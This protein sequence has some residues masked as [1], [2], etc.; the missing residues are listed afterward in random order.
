MNTFTLF[1]WFPWH[2]K[3]WEC[4]LALYPKVLVNFTCSAAVQARVMRLS[5]FAPSIFY[6]EMQIRREQKLGKGRDAVHMHIACILFYFPSVIA[7]LSNYSILGKWTHYLLYSFVTRNYSFI[8][9][10]TQR[11]QDNKINI[12]MEERGRN[13]AIACRYLL[14]FESPLIFRTR[15][16]K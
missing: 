6:I 14:V 16:W 15:D 11:C 7:E 5:I 3:S 10:Y 1:H 2:W 8:Y 12:A 13:S 9:K 4:V